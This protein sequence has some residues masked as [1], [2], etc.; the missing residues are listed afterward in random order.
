MAATSGVVLEESIDADGLVEA[1]R[2][3][4]AI[5]SMPASVQSARARRRVEFYRQYLLGVDQLYGAAVVSETGIRVRR[6]RCTYTRV[7][8]GRLQCATQRGPTRDGDVYPRNICVQGMPG[9]LRTYLLRRLVH[10]LDIENCHVS[11][12]Y[13]LGRGMHEWLE[14]EGRMLPLTLR[15]MRD[16][17]ENRAAFIERVADVH[18]L[19]PDC[20]RVP[21]YRKDVVKGLLLR[22]MYGGSYDSWLEEQGI[23]SR[24]AQDVLRLQAELG[25]LRDAILSARRFKHLIDVESMAQHRRNRRDEAV[26]RGVFSKIAQHLECEVLLTILESLQAQGFGV[27]SLIFDGLTVRHAPRPPDLGALSRIVRERTGFD[28][29]IVEKPLYDPAELT[30]PHILWAA[31]HDRPPSEAEADEMLQ[32]FMNHFEGLDNRLR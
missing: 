30:D 11:L 18:G 22:I 23:Y 24:K 29:K 1:R 3:L 14:F 31:I 19:A 2:H 27:E 7:R 16:L 17:Y 12:M 28:V 26:R 4:E 13:Q 8:G 15:A 5:G 9:V 32:L 10:D 21:G 20:E 6:L 25:H